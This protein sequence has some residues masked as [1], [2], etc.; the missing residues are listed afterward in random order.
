[1][2]D[3]EEKVLSHLQS[4]KGNKLDKSQLQT[5]IHEN[6]YITLGEEKLTI[7]H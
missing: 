7:L 5:L 3:F 4:A 1:M 2:K 6:T